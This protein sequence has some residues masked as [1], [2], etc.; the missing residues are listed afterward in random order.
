MSSRVPELYGLVPQLADSLGQLSEAAVGQ[1]P[2][3]LPLARLRIARTAAT[4]HYRDAREECGH[5]QV[6][7]R[8]AGDR[9]WLPEHHADR[10]GVLPQ[11]GQNALGARG[12]LLVHPIHRPRPGTA[13]IRPQPAPF[14]MPEQLHPPVTEAVLASHDDRRT[15]AQA[16]HLAWPDPPLVDRVAEQVP[17]QDELV[18]PAAPVTDQVRGECGERLVELAGN[19][20]EPDQL[21]IATPDDLLTTGT[22]LEPYGA[23][24]PILVEQVL[25]QVGDEVM[26]RRHRLR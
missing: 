9:R 10:R 19:V 24:V 5:R 18:R 23:P 16:L 3:D 8:V 17:R 7:P 15:H 26:L 14:R 22:G 4:D 21:V 1:P 20:A 2:L 12:H 13:G 25:R 11:V 6:L